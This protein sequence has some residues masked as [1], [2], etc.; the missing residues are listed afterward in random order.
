[1]KEGDQ[2]QDLGLDRKNVKLDLEGKTIP[3]QAWRVPESSRRLR[4]QDF[5]TIGT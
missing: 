3:L 2:I 4:L 5:K 1:M